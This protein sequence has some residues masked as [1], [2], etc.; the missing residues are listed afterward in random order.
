MKESFVLYTEYAKHIGLLSMKQRGA[1]FTAIMSYQMGESLPDMDGATAMAF[2]FIQKKMDEDNAKYEE[3]T[4]KRS[5]AGK[6]GGRPKA[7]ESKGKQDETS[8]SKGKQTKAKKANAFEEEIPLGIE[9]E[10]SK[11]RDY[12]SPLEEYCPPISPYEGDETDGDETVEGFLE[13]MQEHPRVQNDLMNTALL[14]GV[15]FAVLSREIEESRFLKTRCSLSWLLGN[16]RKIVS[17][18]YRDFSKRRSEDGDPQ[19]QYLRE[20]YEQ[21]AEEDARNAEENGC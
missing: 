17:G 18:A 14:S 12:I 5:D 1:L 10:R 7:E 6:K 16:Y 3:L 20:L 13:F 4:K 2:S 15:D 21:A 8:E 11:E 9:K 19:M